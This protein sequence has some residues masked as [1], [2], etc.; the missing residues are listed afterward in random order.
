MDGSPSF[1]ETM[2][3]KDLSR[4]E[5]TLLDGDGKLDE[6]LDETFPA[7]DPP[8][9]TVETGIRIDLHFLTVERRSPSP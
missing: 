4:S 5:Q 2:P 1:L 6:A 8:A 9:N 3:E 7:S